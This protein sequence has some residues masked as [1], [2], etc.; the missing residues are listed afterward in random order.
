MGVLNPLEITAGPDVEWLRISS[1][2]E[3]HKI[4][5]LEHRLIELVERF[6]PAT[7]AE[8]CQCPRQILI[9]FSAVVRVGVLIP[10]E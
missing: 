10:V 8:K 2:Q 6:L 5:V 4:E 7:A 9:G 1:E 3:W